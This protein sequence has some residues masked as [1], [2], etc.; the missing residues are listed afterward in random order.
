MKSKKIQAIFVKEVRISIYL[1]QECI[2]IGCVPYAGGGGVS[3][4]GGGFV[5]RHPPGQTPLG[6]PYP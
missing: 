1:E 4:S 2:L 6:S 5:C 3:A